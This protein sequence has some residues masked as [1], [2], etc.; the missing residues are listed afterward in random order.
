MD[1]LVL[2]NLNKELE[3]LENFS[4]II[5]VALVKRNGLLISSRLPRDIDERKFSALAATMFE[6]I[7]AASS[8]LKNHHVNNLTVEY[9]DYQLIILEVDLN[10]ILVTLIDLNANLGLIFIEIE[11]IIKDIKKIIEK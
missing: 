10:M 11:E 4:E 9:Q 8:S 2:P 1:N 3:R 7:E 5:G 6:A